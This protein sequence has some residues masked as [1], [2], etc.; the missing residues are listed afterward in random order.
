MLIP[1]I[2]ILDERRMV[3]FG[4]KAQ[5]IKIFLDTK[6][7]PQQRH[8]FSSSIPFRM[9]SMSPPGFTQ[10]P[11]NSAETA[12]LTGKA[13]P[14]GLWRS[15]GNSTQQPDKQG[16][17]TRYLCAQ[18]KSLAVVDFISWKSGPFAKGSR[19]LQDISCIIQGTLHSPSVSYKPGLP[20]YSLPLLC[21]ALWRQRS[22][23]R[24]RVG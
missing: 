24:A 7:V 10:V 2:F 18:A 5:I 21:D 20:P 11:A 3:C 1:S 15:P 8:H 4:H 23:D 9:T 19:E 17:D 14:Q 13:P 16:W 12:E 22:W 6:S